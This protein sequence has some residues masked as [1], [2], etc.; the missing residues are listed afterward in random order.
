MEKRGFPDSREMYGRV[1]E[2]ATLPVLQ[3]LGASLG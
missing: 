3:P 1:L 2:Q